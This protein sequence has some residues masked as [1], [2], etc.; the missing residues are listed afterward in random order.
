[1][2]DTPAAIW[3]RIAPWWAEEVGEGNDFQVRLIM[4]ATDRLLAPQAGQHIQHGTAG[5]G[6]K[7]RP[8]RQLQGCQL[9]ALPD[10][11][12]WIYHQ[13]PA[14]AAVAQEG[15]RNN[16]G[17]ARTGVQKKGHAKDL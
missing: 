9:A 15:V 5:G 3:N 11:P 14:V 13:V 2:N 10:R 6:H 17:A 12:R 1:M 4:P 7:A 16:E 8:V